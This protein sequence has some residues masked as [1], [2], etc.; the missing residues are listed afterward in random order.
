MT[1]FV[2]GGTVVSATGASP[3]DVLI[4]GERVVALLA[5]GETS[6]GAD[7]AAG[8][9]RVI[10]ASGRYV[11][12]GGVDG[13]THMEMPF[14]GTF[15]S[16]TFETGTR[17]AAW[18]GTTT[19]IDFIV[20]HTGQRVLDGVAAWHDKADGNC[21]VD[22]GFQRFCGHATNFSRMATIA[23]H[24]AAGHAIDP[25]QQSEIDEADAHDNIFA[26]I[27]LTW[28]AEKG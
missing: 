4:D 8:A 1:I 19:I 24:L 21:A 14:G 11:I 7:V 22:Y 16:D 28:W 27:D 26:N 6:L 2:K 10:D 5:P 25:V 13:H 23:D 12:P 9:E 18:G 20:H 15:A 17:A 3:M